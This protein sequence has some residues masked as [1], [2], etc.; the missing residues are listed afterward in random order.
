MSTLVKIIVTAVISLLMF[1]CNF[2]A[3]FGSGIKGNGNVTSTERAI[4]KN[5]T[6]IEISKGLDVYITQSDTESIKVQADE[7]LQDIIITE[8]KGNVLKI[9]AQDNIRY[10][11]SKKVMLHFKNVTQITATS[12]SDVFSTNTIVADKLKLTT[13]SGSDMELDLNTQ[14]LECKSTSGSYLK[15]KGKTNNLVVKAKSGSDIKA[16]NLIANTCNANATSGS[17]IIIHTTNQLQATASSGGDIKYYGNPEKA[18]TN[19]GTSG[20]ISKQ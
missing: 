11:A 17:A 2:D 10:A 7:N 1:S 20:S 5:F 14:N 3:N 13:T 16:S 9:Y 4:N 6:Q 18:D 15:L 19:D 8:V 12:G